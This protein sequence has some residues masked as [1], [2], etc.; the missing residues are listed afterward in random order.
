M[1]QKLEHTILGTIFDFP[2]STVIA[3]ELLRPE[4]FHESKHKK[5]FE[6]VIDLFQKGLTYDRV[7]VSD[8]SEVSLEYLFTLTS[9][10]D[11]QLETHCRLL[12]EKSIR[13]DINK[14]AS[15]IIK[16][17]DEDIFE[18]IEKTQNNIFSITQRGYRN[19]ISINDSVRALFTEIDSI[20]N[21]KEAGYVS[22]GFYRID[23]YIGGLKNSELY[24]IA[25]RPSIGK[26]ALALKM[27][28]NISQN[29]NVL[30][31]SLEMSHANLTAR[32]ISAKCKMPVLKITSGKFSHE[33]GLRISKAGNEIAKLK[34]TIDD[35]ATQSIIEIRS[36]AKRLKAEKNIKAL[37]VDYLQLC[38]AKAETREREI[39]TISQG[40][41]AIAKELDIPVICLSQ[42]N[43]AVESRQDKK[44]QLS[45]IRES[46]SIEQDADVVMLLHRPEFYGIEK[47]TDDE[48]CFNKAEIIIAK[49][50]NG[51]TGSVKLYFNKEFADFENLAEQRM[52]EEI[53]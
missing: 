25:A 17:K 32:L 9:F 2:D 45:D 49:N 29:Y 18:L 26:T 34:L 11:T 37:F 8:Q 20:K 23:D 33:E 31:D 6:T 42:L 7:T 27:A 53:I 14:L 12:I 48:L 4:Y 15:E 50:R 36:K 38:K 3:T 52:I 40:L 5:I 10:T 19:Y 43:R 30:F 16:E 22:T 24:I 13:R 44:P 41:K 1:V 51:S 28:I 35:T 21:Q 46:G 39:S 47:F